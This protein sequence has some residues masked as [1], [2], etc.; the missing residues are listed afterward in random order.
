MAELGQLV[1]IGLALMLPLANPLTSMT[2]LLSLGRR[3]SA[4]ERQRQISQAALYVFG[5]MVVA[6]YAGS[7]TMQTFGISMPGLRIAGGLIV[8]SIGFSM[9]FPSS[10]IDEDIPE[11]EAVSERMATRK[12]TNIAFVPLALPGT[13]GPGTIAMII[14]TAASI[15]PSMTAAYAPWTLAMAPIIVFALLTLLFW[16]ALRSAD[17]IVAV[18]GLGGVEAIARVMGFLLVCMAVQFVINGV[19]EIVGNYAAG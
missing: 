7:W 11:A 1:G 5:I 9:L 4:L 8:A 10:H 17:R 18:I 16:I 12:S 3:L 6:Y 2:L 19:L 14:S 13:A 15:S